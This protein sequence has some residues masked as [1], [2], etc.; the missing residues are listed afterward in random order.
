MIRLTLCDGNVMEIYVDGVLAGRSSWAGAE[1]FAA[2][3]ATYGKLTLG[4]GWAG[5]LDEVRVH[6]MDVDQ[7]AASGMKCPA[8]FS[9]RF[10]GLGLPVSADT[11]L[12]ASV[13]FNEGGSGSTAAA[14][15]LT[16]ATMQRGGGA[17]PAH[18]AVAVSGDQPRA[19]WVARGRPGARTGAAASSTTSV[20]EMPPVPPGGHPASTSM[21]TG[22]VMV[23]VND[24]CGF[25]MPV[26][27]TPVLA[28]RQRAFRYTAFP[29]DRYPSIDLRREATPD[30]EE[31]D[32]VYVQTETGV[33]C[34]PGPVR[35]DYGIRFANEQAG[36]RGSV[37]IA[38]RFIRRIRVLST[39]HCV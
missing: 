19:Q 35:F 29:S 6:G 21:K 38:R 32:S 4:A 36:S 8:R 9:N 13:T 14:K 20:V 31:G 11:G 17:P 30:G 26:G 18:A 33:G 15:A 39:L 22:H 24:E 37:I 27:R 12:L 7:S 5:Q 16:T 1:R 23:Y 10:G 2:P 28:L 25:T 34:R 3:L